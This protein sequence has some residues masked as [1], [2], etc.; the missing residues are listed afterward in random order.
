[1]CQTPSCKEK[2]KAGEGARGAAGGLSA[3]LGRGSGHWPVS[4]PLL[5]WLPPVPGARARS[6]PEQT[7]GFWVPECPAKVG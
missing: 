6:Y 3:D 7:S 4:C 1:M 2:N 5:C